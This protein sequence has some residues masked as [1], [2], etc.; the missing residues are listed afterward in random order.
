MVVMQRPTRMMITRSLQTKLPCCLEKLPRI[1]TTPALL[2]A[3]TESLSM[4]HWQIQVHLAPTISTCELAQAA[5][6]VISNGSAY[7]SKFQFAKVKASMAQTGSRSSCPMGVSLSHQMQPSL[8]PLSLLTLDTSGAQA[9]A[10]EL[11]AVAMMVHA[12]PA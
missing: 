10:V 9:S 4:P 3:S 8:A 6:L 1:K 12:H 2:K 11:A 7:L 5:N